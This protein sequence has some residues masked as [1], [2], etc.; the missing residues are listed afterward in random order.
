VIKE[1]R[2]ILVSALHHS[3][4]LYRWAVFKSRLA[5]PDERALMKLHRISAKRADQRARLKVSC[6]RLDFAARPLYLYNKL[7]YNPICIFDVRCSGEA[8]SFFYRSLGPVSNVPIKGLRCRT[9]NDGS[10]FPSN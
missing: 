3:S 2:V 4:N 6:E 5:L 1:N 9:D 8:I 7:L 10:L